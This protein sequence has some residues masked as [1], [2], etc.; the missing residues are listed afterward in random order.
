MTGIPY[1]RFCKKVYNLLNLYIWFLFSYQSRN[2]KL[3]AELEI[4]RRLSEMQYQYYERVEMQYLSSRKMIHDMRN[5]LQAIEALAEQREGGGIYKG[6]TSDVG[7]LYSG[8]LH[9]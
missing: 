8:M 3:K 9:G 7:F 6:Y 5:H 1:C 4:R 2:K